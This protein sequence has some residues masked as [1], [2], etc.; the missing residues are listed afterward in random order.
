M[1]AGDVMAFVNSYPTR[2][3]THKFVK[4]EYTSGTPITL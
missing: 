1:Q 2:D 3:V 4:G